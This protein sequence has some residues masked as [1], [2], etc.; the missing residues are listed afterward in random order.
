MRKNRRL[1]LGVLLVGCML[2]ILGL[3]WGDCFEALPD[4]WGTSDVTYQE[5]MSWRVEPLK[6]AESAVR[7]AKGLLFSETP[8]GELIQPIP[9]DLTGWNWGVDLEQEFY[10]PYYI[11]FYYHEEESGGSTVRTI[12]GFRCSPSFVLRLGSN[13][14][15]GNYFYRAQ[16]K[17]DGLWKVWINRDGLVEAKIA[18]NEISKLINMFSDPGGLSTDDVSKLA[19][20]ND[21][22]LML[23]SYAG[24]LSLLIQAA[25]LRVEQDGDG[26][27]ISGIGRYGAGPAAR[28]GLIDEL[29]SQINDIN[30]GWAGAYLGEY[31]KAHKTWFKFKAI[32]SLWP[33]PVLC[34]LFL[35]GGFLIGQ[36]L[37]TDLRK[38]VTGLLVDAGSPSV[39]A[40]REEILAWFEQAHPWLCLFRPRYSKLEALLQPIVAEVRQREDEEAFMAEVDEV[41]QQLQGH[42]VNGTLSG[43][44][45]VAV[46]SERPMSVREDALGQLNTALEQALRPPEP[47]TKPEPPTPPG[48]MKFGP[49]EKTRHELAIEALPNG[50]RALKSEEF[51]AKLGTTQIELVAEH[52]EFLQSVHPLALSTLL[53]H[54]DLKALLRRNSPLVTQGLEPKDKEQV[55]A[56]LKL[57]QPK[58]EEPPLAANGG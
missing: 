25:K 10:E 23:K 34:L 18:E 39:G 7:D 51:W 49:P 35:C 17:R 52:A 32:L 31:W 28:Q 53:N 57:D 37:V 33:W 54:R 8:V 29:Q 26:H 14:E 30:Y 6:L 46:N 44:Y 11:T 50:V 55:L 45:A 40:E 41:W 38:V 13:F 4:I 24:V 12:C 42:K 21:E 22:L 15:M 20:T 5:L 56:T 16:D 27:L 48:K 47:E 36:L 1:I 9:D 19:H 2:A 3:Y 58:E 43:I